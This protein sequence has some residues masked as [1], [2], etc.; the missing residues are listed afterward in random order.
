MT[1]KSPASR[2]RPRAW[3]AIDATI[4]CGAAS[5]DRSRLYRL[6][7]LAPAGKDGGGAAATRAIIRLLA[8][9]MRGESARGKAGHWTYDLNRHIG[10]LQALR[11]ERGRLAGEAGGGPRAILQRKKAAPKDGL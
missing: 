9:A 4:A 8:G 11:A 5:Y 7:P 1:P 2:M 10:L 3:H 6:I